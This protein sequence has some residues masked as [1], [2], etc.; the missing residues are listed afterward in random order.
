MNEFSCKTLK[1]SK[2][3]LLAY[4]HKVHGQQQDLARQELLVQCLAYLTVNVG[5]TSIIARQQIACDAAYLN[6]L[7]IFSIDIWA[8]FLPD[9]R[10]L[11]VS[12][13]QF[14]LPHWIQSCSIMREVNADQP[15]PIFFSI[16]FLDACPHEPNINFLKCVRVLSATPVL[17]CFCFFPENCVGYP[18]S[19]IALQHLTISA[20]RGSDSNH[21]STHSNHILNIL[22]CRRVTYQTGFKKVSTDVIEA[23]S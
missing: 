3:I 23:E 12:R 19:V 21:S 16:W 17:F 1:A 4:S 10:W 6:R 2:P 20:S 15:L 9:R 11:S 8:P 18:Y 14:N 7:M 5:H 13:S 22:L